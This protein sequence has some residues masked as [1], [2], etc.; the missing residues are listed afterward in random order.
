MSETL[1]AIV[2]RSPFD[3]SCMEGP[4]PRNGRSVIKEIQCLCG[5]QRTLIRQFNFSRNRLANPSLREN[6]AVTL[7]AKQI[8]GR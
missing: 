5:V 2:E 6:H 1:R 8:N 7:S 3:N 4:V